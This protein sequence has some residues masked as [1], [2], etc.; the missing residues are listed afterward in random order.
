MS[1]S[2]ARTMSPGWVTTLATGDETTKGAPYNTNGRF[3]VNHIPQDIHAK[4][5]TMN[6]FKRATRPY[7]LHVRGYPAKRGFLKSIIIGDLR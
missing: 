7:R 6:P 5:Q 2:C 3:S 4:V 1:M